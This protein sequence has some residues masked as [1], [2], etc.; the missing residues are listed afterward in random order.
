MA[1][2]LRRM[3]GAGRGSGSLQFGVAQVLV[4]GLPADPVVTGI[5]AFR[6]TTTG[7]LDWLGGPFR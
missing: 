5:D 7:A 3:G 4:D 6:N 2:G 1:K